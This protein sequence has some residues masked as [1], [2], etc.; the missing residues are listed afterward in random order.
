MANDIG[1]IME[2]ESKMEGNRYCKI[3]HR[4]SYGCHVVLSVEL[5]E[6]REKDV[7]LRIQAIL[8]I[9]QTICLFSATAS[10]NITNG[11]ICWFLCIIV[12][13]ADSK[14]SLKNSLSN[15][16]VVLRQKSYLLKNLLTAE[17]FLCVNDLLIKSWS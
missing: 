14:S 1:C 11:M 15:K 12:A 2:V 13:Y 6:A 9:T 8:L 3:L 10:T 7:M 5:W 4:V 17:I 16:K